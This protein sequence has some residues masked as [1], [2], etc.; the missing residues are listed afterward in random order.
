MLSVIVLPYAPLQVALLTIGRLTF[1]RMSDVLPFFLQC[2]PARNQRLNSGRRQAGHWPGSQQRAIVPT[3]R[4][5][6]HGRTQTQQGEVVV[7]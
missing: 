3:L 1:C 7:L 5:Q 4:P 2:A 6:C